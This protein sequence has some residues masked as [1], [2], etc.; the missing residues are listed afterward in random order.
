MKQPNDTSEAEKLRLAHL[1]VGGSTYSYM[2]G[3]RITARNATVTTN[4]PC[5]RCVFGG[6]EF[7]SEPYA[8]PAPGSNIPRC[9]L[10]RACTARFRPDR[11]SVIFI[12]AYVPVAE[13]AP[14]ADAP[15]T[16]AP[17]EPR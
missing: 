9:A 8:T 12:P 7:T 3:F 5:K 2:L 11:K 10:L 1:P 15:G 17:S 13:R 6:D 4:V 16:D 14:Q